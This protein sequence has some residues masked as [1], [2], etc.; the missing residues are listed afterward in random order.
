MPLKHLARHVA[1]FDGDQ[2]KAQ[3]FEKQFKLYR[4]L[5]A[6]HPL[7]D[8]PM[9]WVALAL[10]YIEGPKVDRWSQAYINKLARQVYS[11]HGQPAQYHPEDEA[12]WNK[13]VV[14]FWW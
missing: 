8:V 14:A 1:T 13:F 5:N 12:L 3:K 11:T 9:Q 2:A 10:T 4:L 6:T 7:I